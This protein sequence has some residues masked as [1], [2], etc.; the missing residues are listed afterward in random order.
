MYS[1]AFVMTV[2]CDSMLACAM[3]EKTGTRLVLTLLTLGSR[4][5]AAASSS[6]S[7]PSSGIALRAGTE[8]RSSEIL[9]FRFVRYLR[10]MSLC[11]ARSPDFGFSLAFSSAAAVS[12]AETPFALSAAVGCWG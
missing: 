8:S 11:A 5:D 9:S 4:C 10:S 12:S 6:S 1:V 2:P 3:A 7:R